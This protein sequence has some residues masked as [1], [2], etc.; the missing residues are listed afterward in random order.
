LVGQVR[1]VV[2]IVREFSI[3]SVTGRHVLSA[4]TW[5]RYLWFRSF[6]TVFNTGIYRQVQV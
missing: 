3:E 5:F 4:R 1:H 6:L 2:Y